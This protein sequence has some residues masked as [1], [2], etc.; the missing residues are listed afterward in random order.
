MAKNNKKV[1]A[2]REAYA[3]KQEQQGKN[4]VMWIIGGLIALAVAYVV[5][6]GTVM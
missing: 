5:W 4:I 6:I 1:D 3:K 2:K